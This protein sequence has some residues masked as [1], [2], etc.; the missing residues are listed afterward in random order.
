MLVDGHE[1]HLARE[2]LI[3]RLNRL[4]LSPARTS[5]AD[6]YEPWQRELLELFLRNQLKLAPVMPLISLCLGFVAAPWYGWQVV[7][8]WMLGAIGTSL[9]QVYLCNYYFRSK[10]LHGEAGRI[11][12]GDWL[13]MVTA[14]E[15]MQGLFWVLP[16]FLF[17]PDGVPQHG[18]FMVASVL[19]VAALRFLIAN[20][21]MP[22]LIAGTGIIVLGAAL[23]C[24][25]Q[26]DAFYSSLGAILI[27]LEAFFLFVA[28]RLQDTTRDM[29]VF[30]AQ[31]DAL[32][33]DLRKA[34][35]QA[36]AERRKAERASQA[37]TA[38]L[39][40]MS[41]ELRT[42]L[43]A[44]LGFSEI[45]HGEMFGPL[46]NET[47]KDYAADINTSGRYLLNLINDILDISRIESGRR[48][49]MEQVITV[50]EPLEHAIA[51]AELAAKDKELELKLV[52]DGVLPRLRGDMR[53]LQQVVINLVTNAVKFTPRGGKVEVG[54]KRLATGALQIYVKDNGAGIP[55]EEVQAVLSAFAR[56]SNATTK[57]IDGAGLGLAIVKGIME[58]HD[59]SIE[60]A[61]VLGVGTN[62][63]CNFPAKRVLSGPVAQD[64][65]PGALTE[66][67][68]K[69][70]RLTA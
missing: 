30:R 8:P 63:M 1:P 20:N 19:A 22:V 49:V 41:H 34:R 38:F 35:D 68:I 40:N 25:S 6:D 28:R 26:V 51:F 10:A 58:L 4:S 32:I 14:T 16:L 17:M 42:P 65:D 44:I 9:I 29:L 55:P 54:A 50:R 21:F 24:I 43:N 57:A 33:E 36:E 66:S 59:G 69:L 11:V 2:G 53:A 46:K 67:Q 15:F 47:Y 45:L 48:D 5:Q 61:S 37:K 7:A 12:F 70:M 18:A 56:G 3:A 60:I 64:A 27:L 39:A 62:I 52:I 31:K 13:G 23:R